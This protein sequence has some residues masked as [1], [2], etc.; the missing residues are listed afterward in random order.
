M[1]EPEYNGRDRRSIGQY[2]CRHLVYSIILGVNIP[3]Y[4]NKQLKKIIDD[5]NKGFE[6]EGKHYTKYEGSQMQRRL[7]NEIRKNKVAQIT[8]AQIKEIA[9]IKMPDLNASS[10]ETAMSMIEGTCRSMGVSVVE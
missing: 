7:E 3:Q 2:N 5:N 10:I 6:Y 9:E 4:N 1:F 8:K